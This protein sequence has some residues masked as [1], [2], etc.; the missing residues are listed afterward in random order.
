MELLPEYLAQGIGALG[1]LSWVQKGSSENAGPPR[2][3]AFAGR[4]RDLRVAAGMTQEELALRAG[5]SPNAVSA[6]E[7]GKRRRPYPHT[8]RALAEALGLDEDGRAALLTS[9]PERN[10]A[11]SSARE[12]SPP[13]VPAPALPRPTTPLLGREREVGEVRNLLARR[14]VRLLTLTGVGGVG[15]T[16]L[17]VDVAREAA[18][19]FPDGAAFVGLAPLGDPALV[20]PT[21]ARAVGLRETEGRTSEEVLVDYLGKKDFLL[22]LDNFEHLLEAAPGVAGLI[23]A[24]PGLAVLATSRAPLRVRG[25]REHPVPPLALP[26]STRAP[27]EDDVIGYPSARLFLERARAVSPGFEITG[28]NAGAVAQ[29]CWRLAG[30]PL[31]L[32]LAAAKVRFLH[33]PALLSRLDQALSTAWARDLPER[34]RTMRA[35]L[36]WS[37]ELLPGPERKVFRRLSVFAG[38]FALEAAEAVG[39]D[40]ER[41]EVLGTLGALVEQSLVVARPPMEGGGTRYWL[42]EPVRQY[43]RN[44]LDEGGEGER[45]GERHARYYAELAQRARPGLHGPAQAGWLEELAR[46]H[47]NVGAAMAWLLDRGEFGEAARVGWGIHEF[48][49]RRGYTGEGLRWMERVLAGGGALPALARARALYVVALLSFLRGEPESADSAA[50]EG[51]VAARAAGDPETLAYALGIR[52]LTAL[53]RGDL[54]TAEA[55]LPEALSLFRELGDPHSVSSGLYGL[56]NLALA[57]ADGREAM[58]LLGEAEDLSREAGD[59][60]MLATCLGTQAISTRLEG[61]DARTAGLLRKSVEIAGMLRDDYNVGFSVSGLAGVAAR[62]GR[63]ERAARLFGAADVLSERT[64]AGVSWS[65]L[66][67]LNERDLAS[68]RKMLEPEV[69]EKA[70]AEGRAMD[71]ERT[72]EYTLQS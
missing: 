8:V 13:A 62:E 24:C 7:R 65:V 37:Y 19:T 47:D 18:E 41:E 25:E 29:I 11:A 67:D 52:G 32:E 60:A 34:Q 53:G 59:W 10:K 69:F 22:V 46:D 1:I 5:L 20:L 3:E 30:L 51:V 14:D 38:G 39:A 58:L 6:L 50:A 16:R 70:W 9:V 56:A 49:F 64:G 63:A 57:R 44:K 54:D 17:A 21:V 26:P 23:E 43:A 40:E 2:E 68:A 72:V 27:A 45:A 28:A 33:P 12:E 71:L 55:V 48:W 61:D 15:K 66:R 36:D 42:L 35:T 4:L 31:A